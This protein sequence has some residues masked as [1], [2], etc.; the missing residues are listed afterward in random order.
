MTLLLFPQ[1][2][3][4]FLVAHEAP[5]GYV[6]IHSLNRYLLQSALIDGMVVMSLLVQAHLSVQK[7][8]EQDIARSDKLKDILQ[9][10]KWVEQN[11]KE[12]LML[13]TIPSE[14]LM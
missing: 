12:K 1:I 2:M 14:S 8:P 4:L 7:I 13:R 11:P 3:E 5:W 9:P 6:V 10:L